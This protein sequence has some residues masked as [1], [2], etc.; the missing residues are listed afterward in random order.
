V[1]DIDGPLPE[2]RD[3][4]G[5]GAHPPHGRWPGQARVAVSFVLNLEEGS[6]R[7]FT[8]GDARN[9]TI[10]DMI[11]TIDGAP[12]LTMESHFDYGSR[13]GYWRIVRILA[14]YG[15]TCTV[16]GCAEALERNPGLVKDALAR[17]YEISCHGARWATHLGMT[18]E[19]E[20]ESIR[21]AVRRIEATC[22]R[23][24][25]GWHT[26]CPHT[27][28]TRRLLR[29]EGGF[30]YDSD[31]YD[32]DLPRFQPGGEQPYVILPYSLDTND[33]RFQRPDS[34][35]LTARHFAEY[36]NDAFDC[37]IEEGVEAPKMMTIGLHTRIIGRPSRSRG[38]EAVLAHMVSL[39]KGAV[40]FATREEI[41]RH[42]VSVHGRPSSNPGR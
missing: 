29:E 7:A 36:V 37:L 30:L 21:D 39:P 31:A 38:L 4:V 24:P 23:R 42:W 9:E 34:P 11:E 18:V 3:L 6:E 1:H 26:R 22:G 17:G 19:E 33:M 40:W 20:A 41:A 13:A 32:D 28:H 5:Y 25:T 16:N 10:Y 2:H 27:P 15:V 12:N 8:Y 35:F 14:R